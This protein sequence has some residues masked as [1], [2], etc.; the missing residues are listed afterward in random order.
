[1]RDEPYFGFYISQSRDIQLEE[2]HYPPSAREMEIL[3]E[4]LQSE[5]VDPI[6]VG[7][8]A[9]VKHLNQKIINS[10]EASTYRRTEDLDLF[11]KKQIPKP[12]I[13]WRID[14]AA[15]GVVSWISP[16]G[17]YVDFLIAGQN[18]PDNSKNP[19]N[20]GKDPE[21]VKMGC[22][23]ADVL[24]LFIMKLNSF[25]E[26]DMT[27][28]LTLSLKLGIP[29]ELERQALNHTQRENLSLLKMWLAHENN[30]VS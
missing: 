19:M 5:G 26:K 30:E 18:F 9:I 28:L 20:I 10:S 14:R 29:N 25:R 21:S 17:G 13:G 11:I 2:S 27:D 24:S 16:S 12:P 1:L 7:S 8:V 3:I 4:Y 15:I 22:P 6:I 23:I